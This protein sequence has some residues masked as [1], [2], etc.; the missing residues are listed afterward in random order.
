MAGMHQR[1]A[2]RAGVPCEFIDIGKLYHEHRGICGICRLP[3][4]FDVFAV[5]HIR[6]LSKG[7]PHAWWNVQIAHIAC[8][9]SKGNR[10]LADF[11]S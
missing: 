8:N 2:W 4:A 6:P 9:S 1:R 11:S 7:G 5:D 10:L 3:V